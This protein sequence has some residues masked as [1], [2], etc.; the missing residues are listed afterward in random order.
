MS[1]KYKHK[2]VK[3]I[4]VL[5]EKSAGWTTEVNLV[6]WHGHEPKIDV[7]D[8][9]PDHERMSKGTALSYEAAHKLQ[10]ALAEY[11]KEARP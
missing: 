11:F 3:H 4:A 10:E 5:G 8:W 9:A 7:R 6:S 2:I 1:E